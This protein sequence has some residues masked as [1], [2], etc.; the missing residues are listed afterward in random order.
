[1]L[2]VPGSG[3]DNFK[4]VYPQG[5]LT[6]KTKILYL[7]T[8]LC[9]LASVAHAD[10]AISTKKVS[11]TVDG[12]YTYD[13][14]EFTRL[15][16]NTFLAFPKGFSYYN[17]FHLNSNVG[18][19]NNHFDITNFYHEHDLWWNPYSKIPLDL[20]VQWQVNQGTLN[21]KARFGYRW[22]ISD[23]LWVK[24]FFDRA[25]LYLTTQ[26]H[27]LQTDFNNS[28]GWGVSFEHFWKMNVAPTMFK[29]RVYIAGYMD[30]NIDYGANTAGNNHFVVTETQLGVR[31]IDKLN[32]VAEFRMDQY[33]AKKYGA[34][35]GLEYVV[36]F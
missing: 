15:T 31:L 3:G 1:M 17:V 29:D 34:G 25:H 24:D 9:L 27:P 14:R 21:D 19:G 8:V 11:G 6:M 22:R 13:T 23:T 7:A 12:N 5:E 10:E 36:G 18:S 2:A 4:P 30:H 28:P 33:A 35:F 32:A 16:L 26:F 20:V